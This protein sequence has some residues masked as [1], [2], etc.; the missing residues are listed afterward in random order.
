[1]SYLM[2]WRQHISTWYIKEQEC[3][4]KKKIPKHGLVVQPILSDYMNSRCQM[5]L[6][7][8]Q[9]EPDEDY[10]FIINY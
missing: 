9:S 10:R 8:M 3:Q 4:L 5:D 1:M 2:Y 6:I 7:D